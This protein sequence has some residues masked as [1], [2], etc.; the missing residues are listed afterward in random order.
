MILAKS[1]FAVLLFCEL[2]YLS[3]LFEKGDSFDL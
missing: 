2:L 1:V 3:Y